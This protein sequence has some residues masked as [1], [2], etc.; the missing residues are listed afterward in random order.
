MQ[1]PIAV[2]RQRPRATATTRP[3]R[4]NKQQNKPAKIRKSKRIQQRNKKI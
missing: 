3:A 2:P 1:V 4:I